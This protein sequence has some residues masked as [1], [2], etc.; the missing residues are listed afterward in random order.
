MKILIT[1]TELIYPKDFNSNIIDYTPA[2]VD[3]LEEY[4][5]RLRE[6]RECTRVLF[7]YEE[8]P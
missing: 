4:R 2:I 6:E 7:I 8:L 1:K 3:N 5:K